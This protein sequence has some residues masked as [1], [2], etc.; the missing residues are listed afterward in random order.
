MSTKNTPRKKKKKRRKRNQI[1]HIRSSEWLVALLG[2]QG[3][4]FNFVKIIIYFT[5]IWQW[6]LVLMGSVA[7]GV[8]KLLWS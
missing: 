3:G 8:S 1:R 5:E 6:V 4:G 7:R 2:D